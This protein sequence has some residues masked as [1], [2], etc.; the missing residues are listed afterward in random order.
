MTTPAPDPADHD[1]TRQV[2]AVLDV[3]APRPDIAA[4]AMTALGIRPGV[5]YPVIRFDY[6]GQAIM[7]NDEQ[8][9]ALAEQIVT[10][11]RTAAGPR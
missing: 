5:R 4:E 7:P 8:L 2:E 6:E 9:R 3:L 11:I 10:A 1:T